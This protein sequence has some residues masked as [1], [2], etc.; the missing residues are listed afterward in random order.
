MEMADAV[1]DT[2]AMMY[3]MAMSQPGSS[4]MLGPTVLVEMKINGVPV[5]A[6]VDTGSPAT[7][8]ALDWVLTVLAQ[9]RPPDQTP[10]EW[11]KQTLKRFAAPEVRLKSYGGHR[12]EMMAQ[13]DLTLS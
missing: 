6:L 13:I 7:I 4:S 9:E 1:E 3:G 8:I 10:G 2:T 11:K 12:L 5:K